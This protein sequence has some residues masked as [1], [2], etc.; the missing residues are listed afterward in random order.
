M[1]NVNSATSCG[2]KQITKPALIQEGSK[3][4]QWEMWFGNDS[5]QHYMEIF[6]NKL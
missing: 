6:S 3:V 5:G 1:N 2:T 4:D